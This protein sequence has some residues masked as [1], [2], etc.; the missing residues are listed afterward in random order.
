M[1]I[2][3]FIEITSLI[4]FIYGLVVLTG[5]I[6]AA[7]FSYLELRDYKRRHNFSN[8]MAL[9][10]ANNLPSISILAPAFN[11]EANVIENVKSL[12]TLNYP[13][14]EIVI[15]NDG[16]KDETLQKLI[17]AFKLKRSEEPFYPSIKTKSIKGI[18][19]SSSKS[20]KNF[21][22]IDKI[23]GGKADALNAG[24]NICSNEIICAIDV[25]CV[26][27]PDA[28]LKLAKPFLNNTKKVIAAGGIIRIANSC[29]IE[30]GKI[31]EVRLP[32]TYIARAQILEYFRA[33][34]MGRMAWS[35]VDGLLLISGAFGM[36]DKQT[37]IEAGGYNPNTVGED[38][39]L[40]V[41]MRR[42]MRDKK[43]DY[44]VSFVPDPLCWTEVPQSWNILYRQRNR[45]T[46]GTIETLLLHKKMLFNPKYKVLGILSMPYWLFFEWLA[47]IIEFTGIVVIIIFA[48]I[49]QLNLFTF[50]ILFGVIYSFSL[51]FS[52][53]AL[54]F[55]EFSFQQYKKPKY[56]FKLIGTAMLEPFIYHPFI[57]WSAI[58]GNIDLIRG[59]KSWGNMSRTGLGNTKKT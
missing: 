58:K 2:N 44:K 15:I 59:K 16:S 26:L 6:L 28:L 37:V 20:L 49:G 11:E 47:P 51:L 36:F 24:I 12:L 55:E 39:E 18:Y 10:Q 41:R 22:V 25:D 40:L 17:D 34:L 5:Y 21:K 7:L 54:L 32:Q 45:W 57:M 33:F 19:T 42:I 31:M 52:V 43:T 23:N 48:I 35:K 29:I 53:T 14:F 3:A 46:R 56:I 38:M 27:E 30:D 13:S 8:E 9:L 50:L 1:D 4:F